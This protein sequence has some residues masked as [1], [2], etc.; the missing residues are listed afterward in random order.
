MKCMFFPSRYVHF[1][2][3]KEK[4]KEATP[5]PPQKHTHTIVT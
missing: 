5:F 1:K 4:P 2:I 3:G